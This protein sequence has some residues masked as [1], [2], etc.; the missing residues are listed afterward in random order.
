VWVL[1]PSWHKTLKKGKSRLIYLGKQA[2][3]VLAPWLLG[4]SPEEFVFTAAKSEVKRL[5]ER[6]ETRET[7]RWPSHMAR[8]ERKRIGEKRRRPPSARPFS[9]R[10]LYLAIK[11]A[12]RAAGV[13][14]FS[15]YSLRHLRAIE[16]RASHGLEVCRAVLGHSFAAM[17]DH[18][19][20][21]ADATLASKVAAEC[22]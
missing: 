21:H 7:P 1:K 15:P 2:Q 5:R 17:S 14:R 4:C 8:N 18:Y 19:S 6:S 16:L 13:Q 22:G 10:A 3:A 9:P 20:R 12:C 11:R